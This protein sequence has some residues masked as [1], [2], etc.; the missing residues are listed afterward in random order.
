MGSDPPFD[1]VMEVIHSLA[2]SPESEE[3]LA[4]RLW[5]ELRSPLATLPAIK[6]VIIFLTRK[7]IILRRSGT[8]ILTREGKKILSGESIPPKHV[9]YYEQVLE[10]GRRR[11]REVIQQ[12]LQSNQI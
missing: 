10:A 5:R 8:L 9:S 6:E 2:K 12:L 11:R 1:I 4:D 7:K 3:E